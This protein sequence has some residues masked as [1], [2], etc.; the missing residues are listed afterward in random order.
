LEA[1]TSWGIACHFD[2]V[3]FDPGKREK[4]K[5]VRGQ[6]EG[7]ANDLDVFTIVVMRLIYERHRRYGCFRRHP[8]LQIDLMDMFV[9]D[10]HPKSVIQS[11]GVAGT[12]LGAV[13]V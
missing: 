1:R 8:P 5:N 7:V 9:S 11:N 3:K 4:V 10:C 12:G 13:Q 6:W 2:T